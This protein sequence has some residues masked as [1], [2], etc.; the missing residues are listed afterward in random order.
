MDLK[1]FV[2]RISQSKSVTFPLIAVL[3][4]LGYLNSFGITNAPE[5]VGLW[6]KEGVE[7]SLNLFIAFIA[8]QAIW[9]F[10]KF[11]FLSEELLAKLGAILIGIAGIG[12][13]A[14]L[15]V[16]PEENSPALFWYAGIAVWGLYELEGSLQLNGA[17]LAT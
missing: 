10:S 1:K 14:K 6:T 15:V 9:L 13:F 2:I 7:F 17:S 12:F 8:L 3:F 4:T 16:F 5:H 11:Y